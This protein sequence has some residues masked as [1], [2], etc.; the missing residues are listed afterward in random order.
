MSSLDTCFCLPFNKPKQECKIQVHESSRVRP[1]SVYCRKGRRMPI[2]AIQISC[3]VL[4]CKARVG[5]LLRVGWFMVFRFRKSRKWVRI[6]SPDGKMHLSVWNW[7]RRLRG[8]KPSSK[9]Y[10][11]EN[12]FVIEG[13]YAT[14]SA[15]ALRP[16]NVSL[17]HFEVAWDRNSPRFSTGWIE[18]RS[19]CIRMCPQKAEFC[20]LHSWSPGISHTKYRHLR[21]VSIQV[22][23]ILLHVA[24]LKS[25][26]I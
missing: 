22:Q 3:A 4:F 5:A 25:R 9:Y 12:A 6:A 17:V 1:C 18:A 2:P 13:F 8:K 21:L 7:D 16:V 15:T 11:N 20:F 10:I 24:Y 26:I 23:S 19:L 14:M